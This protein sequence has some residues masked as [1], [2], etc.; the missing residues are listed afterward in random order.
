MLTLRIILFQ[1]SS[2]FP[3]NMAALRSFIHVGCSMLRR[4]RDL[5][6]QIRG[7]LRIHLHS[8]RASA[9]ILASMD[10][11]A[12]HQADHAGNSGADLRPLRGET[13]LPGVRPSSRCRQA[14]SSRMFVWVLCSCLFELFYFI[15][16]L[17]SLFIIFLVVFILSRYFIFYLGILRDVN[18]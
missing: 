12:Y 14:V 15:Y 6:N 9:R 10:R 1:I 11:A 2:C 16:L 18:Y 5:H 7:W 13:L 4:A 8:V 17:L 3:H